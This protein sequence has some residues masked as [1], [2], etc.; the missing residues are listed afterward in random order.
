MKLIEINENKFDVV[1]N[2]EILIGKKSNGTFFVCSDKGE[3]RFFI[4]RSTRTEIFNILADT[5]LSYQSM[6]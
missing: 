6:L 3:P 5:L 4:E 1:M 2:C